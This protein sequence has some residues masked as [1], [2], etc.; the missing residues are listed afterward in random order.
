MATT[1]HA[2]A[3]QEFNARYSLTPTEQVEWNTT[4]NITTDQNIIS[5]ELIDAGYGRDD[6]FGGGGPGSSE[7]YA[8]ITGTNNSQIARRARDYSGT[9]GTVVV[10]GSA[11]AA[12]SAAVTFELMKVHPTRVK[13]LL[14]ESRFEAFPSL[15]ITKIDETVW[16]TD[17]RVTYEQPS[18]IIGRPS[19]IL[20]GE[21]HSPE[22]FGQNLLGDLAVGDWTGTNITLAAEAVTTNLTNYATWRDGSIKCT[23]AVTSNAGT[24]L[25]SVSNPSNHDALRF[26]WA[27]WVHS[28]TDDRITASIKLNSTTT[29]GTAHGGTG[30]ERL[31]VQATLDAA[32]L[33]SIDVGLTVSVGTDFLFYQEEEG[34][35]TAGPMYYADQ[36][37]QELMN[38]D[39]EPLAAGSSSAD[40]I[41]FR[42]HLP[43]RRLLRIIGQGNL[44]AFGTEAST[45]EVG[46]PEIAI[47]YDTAAVK[48]FTAL[49][50][51]QGSN[52]T[53]R[54]SLALAKSNLTDSKREHRMFSP[55][56]RTRVPDAV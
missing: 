52:K 6:F 21:D 13:N 32:T 40:I 24:S 28:L 29:S 11:L 4:T 20:I 35:L 1:T 16:T 34:I 26:S 51:E 41:R 55:R 44:S 12:E 47:L 18:T 9:T 53:L 14:N 50:T 3:R 45:I 19:A 5:T 10:G 31:T 22:T 38:W 7:F 17:S 39:W 36:D 33:S 15:H 49:L 42:S 37:F 56:S 23:T 25:T 2:A 8:Y 46:Q 48:L 30:W 54:E 27:I 43:D